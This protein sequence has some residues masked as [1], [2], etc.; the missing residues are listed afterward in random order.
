MPKSAASPCSGAC[1]RRATLAGRAASS[2]AARSSGA[3][4]TAMDRAG[5]KAGLAGRTFRRRVLRAT[6][7]GFSPYIANYSAVVVPPAPRHDRR[8]MGAAGFTPGGFPFV[9]GV[10]AR[11]GIFPALGKLAQMPYVWLP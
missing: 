11:E 1:W 2:A 9:G 5:S 10:D 4:A 8:R 7:R 6:S 3:D